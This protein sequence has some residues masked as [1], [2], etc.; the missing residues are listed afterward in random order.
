MHRL[1][2]YKSSHEDNVSVD[3]VL[4]KKGRA[5]VYI[6]TNGNQIALYNFF[7]LPGEITDVWAVHKK[8]SSYLKFQME[9]GVSE[10]CW[11]GHMHD[12]L[13][14]ESD[15]K[16]SAG[17]EGH[18]LSEEDML[19]L[20]GEHHKVCHRISRKIRKVCNEVLLLQQKPME[21]DGLIVV[22]SGPCKPG[23][24]TLTECV[25]FYLE[26]Y[27]ELY[28]EDEDIP[29]L[30]TFDDAIALYTPRFRELL[31]KEG[32]K[33]LIALFAKED[34]RLGKPFMKKALLDMWE[35]LGGLGDNDIRLVDCLQDIE[36]L[37]ETY[38][39]IDDFLSADKKNHVKRVCEPYPC[40]DDYDVLYEDRFYQLYAFSREDISEDEDADARMRDILRFASWPTFAERV[41]FPYPLV[42][43]R[44]DG[45]TC[46][47]ITP[48]CAV[49]NNSVRSVSD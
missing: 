33:A 18:E 36:I 5:K 12:K 2:W 3:D 35:S 22:P 21:Q 11:L 25:D 23:F 8:L 28:N 19:Y 46:L 40:F 42:Y 1:G 29:E 14:V 31:R 7:T 10:L 38:H 37:G 27:G 48:R 16:L 44:G 15:F 49:P 32:I 47:L 20:L 30:N 9:K 34:P 6:G 39:G 26:Y 24:K 43:Y 4:F 41:D 17:N 45:S 13:V